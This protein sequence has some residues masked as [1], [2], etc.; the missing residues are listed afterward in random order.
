MSEKNFGQK[1]VADD[2]QL[3]KAGPRIKVDTG[4]PEIR[5]PDDSGYEELRGLAPTDPNSFAT[6]EYVDTRAGAA[7]TG[8]IDGGAPPGVADGALY[9]CTTT[10]GAYT[11]KYLYYGKDA[12]W[13]E[14]VPYEGQTIHV[15]DALTGGNQEYLADHIY[16]WDADNSEWDDMGPYD[17]KT[18]KAERITRVFGATG[19]VNIGAALPAN[20]VVR[21]I[22]ANVT[23]LFDG[24]T[25]VLKVGD[26]VDDDRLMTEA[27]ND[28]TIVGLYQTEVAHKYGSSTQ[29]ISTLTIG[30]SPS[31]GAVEIEVEYS[32]I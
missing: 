2:V 23:A 18:V 10:G 3:G 8:Q 28:L 15:T 6:K 5:K 29:I 4:V 14:K 24:T 31:V 7:V 26:G 12:A 9:I 27:E 17:T 32:L 16:M 1:G 22:K 30:G 19:I 21:S 13:N 20:A 11:E 25:P